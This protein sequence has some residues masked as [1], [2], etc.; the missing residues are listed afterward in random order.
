M[1]VQSLVPQL[2]CILCLV[3]FGTMHYQPSYAYAQ[4]T[5]PCFFAF[6]LAPF[7]TS[8]SPPRPRLPPCDHNSD[9]APPVESLKVIEN[10]K[11][12][13]VVHGL[14]EVVV[15]SPEHVL[16]L[17]ATGERNRHYASTNMNM[18]SSRSHVM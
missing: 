3:Q 5:H 6:F 15:R 13:P 4:S 1:A 11:G 14:K 17:I 8:I 16:E 10:K 7:T 12:E 2:H 9:P 18:H